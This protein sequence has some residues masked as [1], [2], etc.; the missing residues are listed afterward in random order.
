MFDAW[1]GSGGVGVFLAAL[2]VAASAHAGRG[3]AP[4]LQ[5]SVFGIETRPLRE[6]DHKIRHRVRRPIPPQ[7]LRDGTPTNAI[8]PSPGQLERLPSL[9]PNT[10]VSVGTTGSPRLALSGFGGIDTATSDCGCTPPD[11]GLS[12]ATVG[13]TTYVVETNNTSIEVFDGGGNILSGPTDLTTFF[14]TTLN[15][16]DPRV[17]FDASTQRWFVSILAYQSSTAC[18]GTTDPCQLIVAVS[19]TSDPTGSYFLYGFDASNT[20]L[21]FCSGS[22]PGCFPDQPHT[23]YDANGFY[24][25]ADLFPNAGGNAQEVIYAL[26][27]ATMINNSGSITPVRFFTS[28]FVIMPSVPAASEPFVTTN[29][30]TEYML[31]AR[32]PV[33]GSSNIRVYAITNTSL[34]ATAPASVQSSFVDVAAQSYPAAVPAS[35]PN[36]NKCGSGSSA[37]SPLDGGRTS[38]TSEIV[39]SGGLLFGALDS[40]ALDGNGLDRDV[41]AW[42]VIRPTLKSGTLSATVF[43]QGFVVPP[44]GYSVAYPAFALRNAGQG[45]MELSMTGTDASAPGGYDSTAAVPFLGFAPVGNVIVTQNGVDIDDDFTCPDGSS[46]SCRWGDYSAA[47]VDPATG[48]FWT[49]SEFMKLKR[50]GANGVQWG[51]FITEAQ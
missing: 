7:R 26:P 12:V 37:C 16:T 21:S 13:A 39:M 33:D 48:N 36:D 50:N 5:P 4:I 11:Q 32:Q 35:Q 40:G 41:I 44:N 8:V 14:N 1:A 6:M 38:F 49:A 20:D 25:T 22:T 42:F 43:N 47:A 15:P 2:L 34:I 27:K 18:S 24:V 46:G 28:D 17:L 9:S 19:K 23:G 45:I 3:P 29:G 30:G 51:T 10:T 31:T